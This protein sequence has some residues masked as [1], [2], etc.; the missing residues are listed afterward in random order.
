M[1][2]NHGDGHES[3]RDL[4]VTQFKLLI[5]FFPYSEVGGWGVVWNCQTRY[6]YIERKHSFLKELFMQIG[7]HEEKIDV[8][9]CKIHHSC[10]L[11]VS[12]QWFD[13]TFLRVVRTTVSV[14]EM[15]KLTYRET[16]A[17][18]TLEVCRTAWDLLLVY[19]S[20]A[21]STE[22]NL[23]SKNQKDGEG[24]L[25]F[26]WKRIPVWKPSYFS[27]FTINYLGK[28]HKNKQ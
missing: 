26:F 14:P 1:L 27:S 10:F 3:R 9:F 19:W 18:F 11:P 25:T 15:G 6:I 2:L 22:E 17:S 16:I 23:G 12:F 5:F 13:D 8:L 20:W 24:N 28:T 21:S 4:H 7:K